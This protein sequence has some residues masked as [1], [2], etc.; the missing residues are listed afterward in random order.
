M[1]IMGLTCPGCGSSNVNFDPETRWLYCN[2]CGRKQYYS[3]AQIGATGKVLLSKDNAIK[4]FKAGN[5]PLARDFAN[6]VLNTMQDNVAAL[7][8]AA[9]CNEFVNGSYG[10]LRRFFEKAD[11]VAL[12][13]DEVRDLIDLFE[14]TLHN[15]RDYEVEM[16][17]L[18]I[19]NMQS[20]EDRRE[21]EAF[22]DTV[23][24]YCIARYASQDF[25]TP[26]RVEFYRDVV[27]N[28]DVP[29]TCFALVKGIKTNPDSP[30]QTGSFL[31][32]TR[33]AFFTEHYVRPVGGIVQVM[34]DGPYKAKITQAYRQVAGQYLRNVKEAAQ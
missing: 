31:M 20:R 27:S 3:R 4:F 13:Y 24:P 12:E 34:T 19:K 29:K 16:V 10:S 2:Q 28:C 32:R 33:T 21:L 25:L 14:H 6:D 7:F 1:E 18:V 5:W 11:S 15:M 17:A 22:I 23:C 8:M 30:Y 26:E 9:Y